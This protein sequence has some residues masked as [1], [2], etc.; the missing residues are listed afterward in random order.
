MNTTSIST[1]R[2]LIQLAGTAILAVWSLNA[3]ALLIET[4]R[5]L[6]LEA[7]AVNLPA[8]DN[9]S[10]NVKECSDCQR[11]SLS[12][13][14]AE[15]RYVVRDDAGRDEVMTRQLFD[16]ELRKIDNRSAMV[17]VF[18]RL[19]S[20]VV[21]EIRLMANAPVNTG[22]STNRRNTLNNSNNSAQ[23]LGQ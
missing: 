11:L 10:L 3:S 4:H 18:Y 2:R 16:K 1:I 13:S 22:R 9:G 8:T 5:G 12:V 6:E 15:T 7:T 19:D 21:T 23:T 20:N 14:D 17:L